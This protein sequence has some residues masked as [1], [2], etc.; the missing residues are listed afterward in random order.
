M[1]RGISATISAEKVLLPPQNPGIWIIEN[2]GSTRTLD[3]S[4]ALFSRLG[5]ADDAIANFS[6]TLDGRLV[7]VYDGGGRT[8]LDDF[9]RWR[10]DHGPQCSTSDRCTPKGH[11][12][13]TAI[14]LADLE[15]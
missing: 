9:T 15:M 12:E 1:H 3:N 6:P 4:A 14:T 2:G 13:N 10:R 5:C 8:I 7:V 11:S